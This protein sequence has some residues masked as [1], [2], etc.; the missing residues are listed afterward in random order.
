MIYVGVVS[1]LVWQSKNVYLL[2]V[3][4]CLEAMKN[5]LTC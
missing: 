1:L 4:I 5:T 2:S 3:D